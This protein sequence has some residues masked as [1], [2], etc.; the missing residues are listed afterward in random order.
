MQQITRKVSCSYTMQNKQKW[1]PNEPKTVSKHA[2]QGCPS[3][4]PP[5]KWLCCFS[6]SFVGISPL[7]GRGP[8]DP[9]IP[10]TPETAEQQQR[11]NFC[12]TF[13]VFMLTR[14]Y[15]WHHFCGPHCVCG[16]WLCNYNTLEGGGRGFRVLEI[17]LDMQP[18]H[19]SLLT[20]FSIYA[21]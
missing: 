2:V 4:R 21:F 12:L 10:L 14:I 19:F 16:F 18:T 13:S 9:K 17:A 5:L 6:F 8:V 11:V 20:Q 7:R 15:S 3:P 1:T